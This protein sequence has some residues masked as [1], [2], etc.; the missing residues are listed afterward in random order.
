[1][2]TDQALDWLADHFGIVGSYY[3]LAG[4]QQPT[5]RETKLALLRANGLKLATDTDIEQAASHHLAEQNSRRFDAEIILDQDQHFSLTVEQDQPWHIQLEEGVDGH[6]AG[7]AKGNIEL[8]N[9]PIGVHQLVVGEGPEAERIRLIVAPATAPSLHEV[10]DHD[11]VWGV[12]AA[13]YGLH[14]SD[15]AGIGNYQHLAEAAR[16]GGQNGASFLG[17]NP[18]HAL[19]WHSPQIIS[20]Y[21]PTHRGFLNSA[22]IAAERVQPQSRTSCDLIAQWKSLHKNNPDAQQVDYQQHFD[23]LRPILTSLF[24][25]FL[26]L[27]EPEQ[28]SG[29]D[30]FCQCGGAALARFAQFEKLS[31]LHGEDWNQWPDTQPTSDPIHPDDD[32]DLVF[33]AWLQ[34]IADGQLADAQQAGLDA[35]MSLGLYLDLAVGARRDGAEAWCE[36]SSIAEG[37]SVGAPPDHLAP[38][39]QNWNLAAFAPKK[40]ARNNYQAFRDILRQ[41]MR[42]CGIIRIDHVLG[43][44]RS[45]WI[46]DDGSAGGYIWQNFQALMALVRIEAARSNTVVVG[47]DLGLVP[48]GFRD[49]MNERNIYSYGVLQYEKDHDNAF[50]APEN[51]RQKS[52][53]CF[54][55]HDTPTLAGYQQARD[56][57]WWQ[58][59]G[60][61]DEHQAHHSRSNRTR[62]VEQ[63]LALA[64]DAIELSEAGFDQLRH[65]VYTVL[66]QSNAAMVSVQL[67]DLFATIEAQNLPGTTSEHPNWQ[68]KYPCSTEQLKT[69]PQLVKIARIMAD[70]ARA[71]LA[72][73]KQ[74]Q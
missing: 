8:Q 64:G 43:L 58:R 9:L 53:V 38:A 22:H 24:Q 16:M 30:A 44:N 33:H 13:L 65:A 34:W 46:P 17:I 7:H 50:R 36:S 45:Y 71:P 66:A 10:S 48:E 25:D 52:L 54:G 32:P 39:G 27:A 63:L 55:T 69:D 1:M 59:L 57:E 40:L 51:F 35:G 72:E 6:L 2:T 14:S 21:S 5:S 31:G 67:D 18:V 20:P 47:E 29:F 70:H 68:R 61:I 37:V 15:Q 12:N 49:T 73:R 41:T 62:E 26:N 56:V 23:H 42:H 19:G 3:D 11:R 4:N 60:W 74:V 28:R